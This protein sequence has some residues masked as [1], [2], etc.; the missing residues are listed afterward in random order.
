MVL[1]LSQK[2]VLNSLYIEAPLHADSY[3]VNEDSKTRFLMNVLIDIVCQTYLLPCYLNLSLVGPNT[4]KN[5]CIGSPSSTQS[6][7]QVR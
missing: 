7:S 1:R 2:F 6:Q 3:A 5:L 4:D